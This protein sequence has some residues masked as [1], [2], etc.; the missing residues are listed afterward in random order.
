MSD[1]IS[2]LE[3][4]TAPKEETKKVEAELL[5]EVDEGKAYKTADGRYIFE[6]VNGQK[7]QYKVPAGIDEKD[8]VPT[9]T[10]DKSGKVMHGGWGYLAST[11]R[12][13][14]EEGA[15]RRQ[16]VCV[17]IPSR[18]GMVLKIQSQWRTNDGLWAAFKMGTKSAIIPAP[19]IPELKKA[20]ENYVNREDVKKA[21]EAGEVYRAA[22]KTTN[23]PSDTLKKLDAIAGKMGVENFLK[24]FANFLKEQAQ[25]GKEA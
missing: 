22:P 2:A 10:L 14:N 11:L 8:Y 4:A 12:V 17:A 23:I 7:F 5:L 19:R 15:A 1:I 24:V 20:I 3:G 13:L 9:T 18:G 6:L 21:I 16:I 25:A